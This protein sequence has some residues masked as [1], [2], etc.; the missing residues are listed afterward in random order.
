[1]MQYQMREG[2]FLDGG[3]TGNTELGKKL[4]NRFLEGIGGG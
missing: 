2:G 4:I 3:S 1:M